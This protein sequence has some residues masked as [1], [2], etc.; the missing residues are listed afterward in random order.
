LRLSIRDPQSWCKKD[1]IFS[2][3]KMLGLPSVQ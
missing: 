1:A 3:N 2:V